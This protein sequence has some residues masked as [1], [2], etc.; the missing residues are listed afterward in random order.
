MS[1]SNFY[2]DTKLGQLWG[3]ISKEAKNMDENYIMM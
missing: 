3:A 2:Y 1:T